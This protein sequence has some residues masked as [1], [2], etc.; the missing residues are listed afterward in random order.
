MRAS[1][2]TRTAAAAAL[3]LTTVLAV[4]VLPAS[5]RSTD[6]GQRTR[7]LGAAQ[8][9]TT[10]DTATFAVQAGV[11]ADGEHFSYIVTESSDGKDAKRR[12]VNRA[13]KLENARN[14]AAVQ[15]GWYDR[16]G[17]LHV[18]DT[19]DFTPTRVVTP[20]PGG[21]PPLAASPGAIGQ[22]H[23][24][25]LV[26]LSDGT[27]INA[28]HVANASGAHDKLA[29]P[30]SGGR[31]TFRET[32]GFYNGHEVYYVSFDSS[33]PD[34][35]ALEGVTFAPNLN[36]APGLGDG[37]G[38]SARSGIAPFA[39]G[40]T[41]VANPNRQGLNSALLGE[42]DPLNVVQSR[43][44]QGK[45]SPLWDV[46]LSMWSPAAVAAATNT[47]QVD[48]GDVAN[49][50]NHGDITGPGGAPWGAIGAIVN[51][52]IVSIVD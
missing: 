45:Y 52:P 19:V 33:A 29:A 31:A 47:R 16:G 42:G 7:L 38:S 20:G 23:Y 15:H 50:A 44:G 46:H 43:P 22:A 3:G 40:Q 5:A 41:G 10:A 8:E 9:D 13:S 34:I 6:A 48:F 39:N 28:P 25:P 18:Q 17:T 26:Q 36:A 37:G 21:F 12:N 24:S 51:C 4:G 11:D 2:M 49:R 1:K 32:E 27:V 35:A 14:T 30:I